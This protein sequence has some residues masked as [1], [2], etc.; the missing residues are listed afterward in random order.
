MTRIEA[1]TKLRSTQR[2]RAILLE[3]GVLRLTPECLRVAFGVKLDSVGSDTRHSLDHLDIGVEEDTAA[4]IGIAK[5][6]Q[7]IR[8]QAFV[9]TD[10]PAMI[11]GQLI[12]RVGDERALV[13]FGVEHK[14]HKVFARIAFDIK[15]D[16]RI[17][18]EK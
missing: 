1:Q 13:G 7:N 5:P 2:R 12:W 14:L 17:V 10:V 18:G 8:Q 9:G 6:P 11:R 3:N 15:F 4:N 16:T